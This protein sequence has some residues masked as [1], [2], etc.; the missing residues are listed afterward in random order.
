MKTF[1]KVVGIL[2]GLV[3]IVVIGGLIY[4]NT[5]YPD[6]EA[7]KDVKIEYTAERIARGEY[8]ANHV[9]VC[10]DCHSERDWTKF[11]GPIK[12]GTEGK[13]GDVFSEQMGFPG[14]IYVRNITPAAL[15]TWSDGELIRA[16]TC[17]VRKNGDPLFPMMPYLNFNHLTQEDIYSIV[18]YIRSLKPIQNEVPETE[19][20]FPL[21]LIV[22]TIP[23]KTYTPAEEI[24]RS[25]TAAY[26]KYLVTIASCAECHTQAVDGQPIEGMEFAGGQE[27]N[28]GPMGIV[29]TANITPHPETGIGNWTKEEFVNRFKQNIPDSNSTFISVKAGEFNSIMPWVMYGGMTEEDLGAIY[30]YLKTLKPVYNKVEKFTPPK[31]TMAVN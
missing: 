22:R 31:K 3:V 7:P 23:L 28:L 13:G 30:D 15:S 1:L 19:L 26:G 17:G 27:F 9:A 10:I 25:N 6:V 16:I 24:D 8:L 2:A 11:A 4:F 21:N 5:A 18:S 12:P 14:N 29:R 20:N